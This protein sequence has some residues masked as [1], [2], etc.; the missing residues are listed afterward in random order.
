MKLLG[1]FR[2]NDL[3]QPG[4]VDERSKGR[5]RSAIDGSNVLTSTARRLIDEV[6]LLFCASRVLY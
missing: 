1:D 2:T 6:G 3:L 4:S 5:N